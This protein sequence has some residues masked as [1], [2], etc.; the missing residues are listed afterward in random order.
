VI[1]VE[2]EE[3]EEHSLD[4]PAS[5]VTSASASDA[6]EAVLEHPRIEPRLPT[7]KKLK[8][9]WPL[10]AAV[11][12]IKINASHVALLKAG[13]R[14]PDKLPPLCPQDWFKSLFG[15]LATDAEAKW[16]A[17]HLCHRKDCVEPTHI[18]WE[19]GWY[20][21][22]RDNCPGK[23][24]CT[25]CHTQP[26]AT[27][28]HIPQCI[29]SHRAP[30]LDWKTLPVG[31]PFADEGPVDIAEMFPSSGSSSTSH[32]PSATGSHIVQTDDDDDFV[33]VE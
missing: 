22:A 14:R 23:V 18:V 10:F 3:E 6:G 27:C 7:K 29:R 20:N 17:S 28:G 8:D 1:D 32:Y 13:K 31:N 25:T 26:A 15:R 19:P 4:S 5:S 11:L 12:P 24:E 16:V 21:R 2:A 33:D 30:V 9:M